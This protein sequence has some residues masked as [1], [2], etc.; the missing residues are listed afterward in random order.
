MMG[1]V[2][3]TEALLLAKAKPGADVNRRID[4]VNKRIDDIQTIILTGFA[5][6][7][8]GMFALIGFVSKICPRR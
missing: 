3:L 7:F 8:P 6:L 1:V 2:L 5:I 4:D